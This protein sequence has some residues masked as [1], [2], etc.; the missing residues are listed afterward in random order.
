MSEYWSEGTQPLPSLNHPWLRADGLFETLKSVKGRTFFL[1]RHL[2]RLSDSANELLFTPPKIDEIA[3]KIN[4]MVSQDCFDRGRLRLTYFSNGQYLITHHAIN[5][6]PDE[7]FRLGLSRYPRFSQG[8]LSGHKTLA[9]TQASYGLRVAELEG[10]DDLLYLNER[11]EVVETGLAN[12]VIEINGEL[13][14]PPLHSGPLP[15]IVRAVLLEWFPQ[16]QERM[17][18]LEEL[19]EASG[20]YLLSSIRELHPVEAF[21]D[22]VTVQHFEESDQVRQIRSEY[23]KRSESDADS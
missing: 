10:Y 16:I 20:L 1:H 6:N 5:L 23:L 17:L 12:I 8:L 14:T 11:G 4:Q 3:V 7:K 18:H 15:G 21:N 22:G 13:I 19:K 2:Q 9:Y